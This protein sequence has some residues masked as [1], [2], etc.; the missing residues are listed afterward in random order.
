MRRRSKTLFLI[1]ALLLIVAAC[2]MGA[3]STFDE[4][5]AGLGGVGPDDGFAVDRTEQ[6]QTVP[7]VEAA[8]ASPSLGTGA[9]AAIAFQVDTLGRDI[10]FTADMTVAVSDV[11]AT[12][13]EATRVIARH[14]GFLFGQQTTGGHESVSTLT[15]KVAPD[16]FH[17]ALADLGSLGEVRTQ[18][19]TASDVTDRIVDLESQIATASASVERLRSLLTGATD[20]EEIVALEAELLARETTLES[21]RGQ[22]RTLEDQVALATITLTIVQEAANPELSVMLSAYAGHDDGV[23]CP[24]ELEAVSIEKNEDATLCL[25]IR[26]TGDTLLTDFEIRDPV[27]DLD[28]EQMTVVF[29]DLSTPLEPGA[30]IMLAAD[31]V[32]ERDLRSQVTVT[33]QPVNDDGSRISGSAAT[34]TSSF[35]VDTYDPGGIPT[36]AEGVEASWNW[37]LALGQ[38]VLLVA[39]AALPFLWVPVVAWF[40]W[41]YL[42]GR[43]EAAV[44]GD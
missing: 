23:G 15:F 11:G 10:I 33:A 19:I 16:R 35:F 20:I 36:F 24:G 43:R 1:A 31:L 29:G 8:E 34:R 37:L 44:T 26:N 2:S 4:V 25:E 17:Q 39:G 40:G 9:V 42:R 22:L 28:I 5:A 18:N 7:D 13:T 21:L 12:S 3:E 6:A 14:G 27:F 32:A 30:S 38:I 41:R